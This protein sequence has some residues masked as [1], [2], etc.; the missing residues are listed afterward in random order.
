MPNTPA[1]SAA[2]DIRLAELLAALSVATDL[3]MAFP[4]ETALRTCMLGVQI[5]REL[6]LS[7]QQLEELFYVTLL[8]HV[9]CTAFS[10][11]EGIVVGDDNAIRRDFTGIDR[12]RPTEVAATAIRRLGAGQGPLGR[13]RL[14]TAVLAANQF[15]MPRIVAAHCDASASLARLLGMTEGVI[16]ALNHIFE[17]WDGKGHPLG[18]KGEAI[19]LSARVAHFSHTVVLETWRRGASGAN[20]MVRRRAGREFDPTLAQIFLGRSHELLDSVSSDS[21]WDAVLAAEPVSGPWLPASRIDA[22]AQA[23]AF[24]SDLKSPYTLG[25][26]QAVAPLAEAAGRAL[27]LGDI[28]VQSLRRAALLHHLGRVAIA[29]GIWDKRG[30]LSAAEWER[31][32][33]YPYHTER[34]VSRAPAL[35]SLATLAASVQERLDG[36]GY[37][38]GVPAALLSTG[39]RVLA[40]ADA[41]QAMTEERPHRPALVPQLAARELRAEVEAGRL[42]RE[43]VNAV[44]EFAG[45]GKASAGRNWPADLTDREVEVLRQVAQAKPNKAI[46]QTLVISD[47]TVRNH[48]RHIY[49]KIGVSSRAGAALFAMEHDLIRK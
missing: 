12:S 45:H 17:R 39:A 43:A 16:E 4:P 49:E 28:E 19:A 42:D 21:V 9:G 26:C 46:A 41:Y 3:A 36:S 23:F 29:N 13:V 34:I 37:H 20:E 27:S 14:I 24:F 33:L 5:G 25:H 22:V 7:D 47:E 31:L 11:E 10:H 15:T 2:N 6:R 18:L 40:A 32:R 44:L 38:R 8:R 1:Q 35:Q 48:V 30:P